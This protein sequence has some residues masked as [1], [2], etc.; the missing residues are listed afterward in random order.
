MN[1]QKL[2]IKC[3]KAPRLP[4]D[5]RCERCQQLER[6]M[7]EMAKRPGKNGKAHLIRYGRGR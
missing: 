7:V 4:N 1:K 3:Q 2:C 6:A 5:L